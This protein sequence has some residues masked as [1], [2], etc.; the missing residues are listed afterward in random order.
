MMRSGT[1]LLRRAHL[2]EIV[3]RATLLDVQAYV[4]GYWGARRCPALLLVGFFIVS[5][6]TQC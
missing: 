2:V 6:A 3:R 5:I 1:G 4:H